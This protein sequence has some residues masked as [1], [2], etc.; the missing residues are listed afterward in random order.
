MKFTE[1]KTC[2]SVILSTTNPTYTEPGWNPV[3][4]GEGPPEA[5][6]TALQLLYNYS[7]ACSKTCVTVCKSVYVLLYADVMCEE[8]QNSV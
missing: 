1:E 7:K 8:I 3:L 4:S 2:P 5:N 6:N